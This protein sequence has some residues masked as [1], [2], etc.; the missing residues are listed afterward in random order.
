MEKAKMRIIGAVVI[1]ATIAVWM[2]CQSMGAMFLTL[3]IGLGIGI[4]L[5]KGSFEDDTEVK[6]RKTQ[7]AP[8]TKKDKNKGIVRT[9]VFK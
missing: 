3:L 4:E 2:R 9:Q 6:P 1:I 5:I 7:R 8:A